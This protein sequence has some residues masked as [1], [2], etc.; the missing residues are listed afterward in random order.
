MP[1]IKEDGT[2]SNPAANSY[3]DRADIIAYA[4]ARGVTIA[5]DASADILGIAAMDYLESKAW[6]GD[7]VLADQPLSWPRGS[8][9][10]TTTTSDVYGSFPTPVFAPSDVVPVPVKTAQ[11]ELALQKK[12]GIELMPSRAAGQLL[13]SEKIDVIETEYYETGGLVTPVLL[14]VEA[15]LKPFLSVGFGPLSAVRV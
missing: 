11:C 3:A 4:A 13:K 7:P 10:I 14:R 8:V 1:L 15:L 12:N 6:K 5:D 9:V 2:G